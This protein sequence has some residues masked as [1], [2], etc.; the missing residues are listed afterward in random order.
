MRSFDENLDLYARVAVEVG[1]NLRKGQRLSINAS[2]TTAEYVRRVVR[3]AYAAGAHDVYIDWHDDDVSLSRVLLSPEA[4]LTDVP[5]WAV[6]RAETL[7]AQRAAMLGIAAPAPNLY[8]DV[9]PTRLAKATHAQR[10]AMRKAN[11]ER[12]AKTNWLGIAAATP[13]WAAQVYPEETVDRAVERLWETL[14][15]LC[16][17]DR[18]DPVGAWREHIADLTRRAEFLNRNAFR[19]LRYSGPGTEL[20]VD[21]PK[22]HRWK[23]AQMTDEAG[24][25][26]VANIP[27]EEAFTAPQRDG[28]NGTVRSTLPLNYQG[29]TIENIRLRLVDGE[30]VEYDADSGIEA[31]RSII[32]ADEGSRRLGEIALV[33]QDSPIARSGRLFYNTLYDENAS[34]HIA[35]GTA[36]PFCIEGGTDMTPEEMKAA[37]AN[38]SMTHVDFMIGSDELDVTGESEDGSLVP[39][40]RKG[41]WAF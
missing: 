41:R 2:V 13:R 10:E 3:A 22:S 17:I 36:I 7:V 4:A 8:K 28:V 34:C 24:T 30:I 15:Q 29:V 32:E 20:T 14:F 38:T 23:T 1:L 12:L 26:Y 16:R 31:L 21:L 19:R 9:P 5:E 33:S 39:L 25:D 37:G 35:I 11:D 18:E 40:L 27:T 6:Q